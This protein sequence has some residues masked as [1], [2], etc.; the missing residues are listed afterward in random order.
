MNERNKQTHKR[1]NEKEEYTME[2]INVG[3][4]ERVNETNV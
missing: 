3:A 4:N 1:K 2:Q